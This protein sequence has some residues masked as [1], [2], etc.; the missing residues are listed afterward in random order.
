MLSI[1]EEALGQ[2]VNFQKFEI[3][4]MEVR[5]N[6][7]NIFQFNNALDID[8]YLGLPSLICKSKNDKSKFNKDHV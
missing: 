4:F 8:K 6:V 3:F 7:E 1:Y 2:Q 5:S